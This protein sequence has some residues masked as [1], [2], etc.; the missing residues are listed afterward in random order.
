MNPR[1]KPLLLLGA[2]QVGKT[3]L[4]QE[5]GRLHYEKIAYIR[6][7]RDDE[8]KQIFERSGYNI[9]LLMMS[10]EA[11]IRFKVEAG[12]T[13]IIFDEIQEYP[14]A[15]T[16]LKYF[17]KDARKHHIIAAGSLLGVHQHSGTGFPVGKVNIQTLYPMSFTE[18][19]QAIGK[20]LLCEQLE[21]RNRELLSS[22]SETLSQLLR[23]YYY[24]GGM[25][26]IS[27]STYRLLWRPKYSC[28]GILYRLN[29][30]KRIRVSYTKTCR[31]TCA[32]RLTF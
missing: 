23:V 15:L 7:D 11:K 13:L 32:P 26:E 6:F 17:C 16:S 9:P 19:L 22:F 4:M 29:L 20:E 21:A 8:L 18:F 1:R 31:K 27:A 24:V 10:I 5:F 28:C 25:P 12:K 30:P 2:R 3:W 14:H